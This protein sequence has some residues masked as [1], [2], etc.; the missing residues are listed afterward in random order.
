MAVNQGFTLRTAANLPTPRSSAV[1]MGQFY[2]RGPCSR[3]G[4][5]VDRKTAAASRQS[6]SSK[7]S[8]VGRRGPLLVVSAKDPDRWGE[9]WEDW[10]S[11]DSSSSGY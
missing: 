1:V 8:C 6:R 3:Q 11:S 4:A 7:G 2:T 9:K 10:E 5:S